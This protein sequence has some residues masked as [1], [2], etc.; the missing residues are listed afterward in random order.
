MMDWTL[1]ILTLILLPYTAVCDDGALCESPQYLERGRT[2][3]VECHFPESYYGVFW[4]NTTEYSQNDPIAYVKGNT[5]IGGSGYDSDEYYIAPNGS[6]FITKVSMEDDRNFTAIVLES[7]RDEYS[8]NDIRVIVTVKPYQMQPHIDG[9]N[10]EEQFCFKVMKNFSELSCSVNNAR[11]SVDLGWYMRTISTDYLLNFERNVTFENFLYTT[12]VKT[13]YNMN[14]Y[15]NVVYVCKSVSHPVLLKN[16][17][18]L[19]LIQNG[20]KKVEEIVPAT[21]Y[22]ERSTS[23]DLPCTNQDALYLLWRKTGP[24]NHSE[25]LIHTVSVYNSLFTKFY[26]H[27]YLLENQRSLRIK[28]VDITDEGLYTCTFGDGI[29]E[30]VVTFTLQVYGKCYCSFFTLA[31]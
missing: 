30:S 13:M 15:R 21:I 22:A 11:P 19:V 6:L 5:E 20:L 25:D 3:I 4:Y 27:K 17:Y 28:E 24:N 26:S 14:T 31:T 10:P 1:T 12:F 8:P 23:I 9:C 29:S 2:G 16:E 7:P 18:S